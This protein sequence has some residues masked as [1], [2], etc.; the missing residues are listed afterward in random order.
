MYIGARLEPVDPDLHLPCARLNMEIPLECEL[1]K[2]SEMREL[3]YLIDSPR[4]L[5]RYIRIL[6]PNKLSCVLNSLHTNY[7]H[8]FHHKFYH[9]FIINYLIG[10]PN[11]FLVD[12][13]SGCSDLIFSMNNKYA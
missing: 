1:A 6:D 4:S 12:W 9:H 3:P 8:R 10:W 5:L 13:D 7:H 11:S 2:E